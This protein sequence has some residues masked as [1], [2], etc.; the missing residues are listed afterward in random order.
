MKWQSV[1]S[2]RIS[3]KAFFLANMSHELRTPISGVIGLLNLLATENVKLTEQSS[4]DKSAHYIELAQ[5]T[6]DHLLKI[7]SNILDFSKVEAGKVE[8]AKAPFNLNHLL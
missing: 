8:V 4:K 6:A 3:K 7:I 2:L 1:Q 5:N